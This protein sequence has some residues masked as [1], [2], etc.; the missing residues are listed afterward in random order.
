MKT[1]SA[2]PSEIKRK[3]YILDASEVTLGRLSSKAA[4]LLI[5]KHKPQFT[6]H[7]DCGD[8][9]IV[10]NAK[11]L[12]VTGD[13]PEQKKYYHHSG[14]AGGLSQRSLAEQLKIDTT[15]VIYRSIRGMLPVNR[16]REERLSRLKI[17]SSNEHNHQAQKPESMSLKE[18]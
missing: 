14:H 4:S 2:K 10:I 16:L 8:Y 9:V 17:Y 12:I 7:I 5:G 3:W 11:N 1:Y 18:T 15:T 13:K 6:S